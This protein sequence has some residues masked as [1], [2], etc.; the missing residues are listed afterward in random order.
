MTRITNMRSDLQ[1]ESFGWLFKSPHA[2]G[3]GIV[4]AALQAA[5]L[6]L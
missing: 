6:V 4:A 2:G 1:A 5:R 3:G